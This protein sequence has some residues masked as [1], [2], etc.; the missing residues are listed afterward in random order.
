MPAFAFDTMPA[1]G[2]LTSWRLE[3][4]KPLPAVARAI[5][6]RQLTPGVTAQPLPQDGRRRCSNSSH[7][8]NAAACNRSM[9][10]AARIC[11][12]YRSHILGSRNRSS[13][14]GGSA[15]N[16]PRWKLTP[17]KIGVSVLPIATGISDTFFSLRI[18]STSVRHL[19]SRSGV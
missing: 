14:P 13:L 16:L 7:E 3:A 18:R 5:H 12:R 9:A 17:I 1:K 4:D 19:P 15:P 11:A 2:W 10:S 6:L 8:I